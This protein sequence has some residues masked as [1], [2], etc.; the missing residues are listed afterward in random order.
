MTRFASDRRGGMAVMFSGIVAL[1]AVLLILVMGQIFDH[2]HKRALQAD[3]DLAGRVAGR[4]PGV[5]P[6]PAAPGG[7]RRGP[8][9][10]AAR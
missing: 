8:P 5:A 1:G 6:P 10:P 7:A 4:G 9:P 2:L 3:A